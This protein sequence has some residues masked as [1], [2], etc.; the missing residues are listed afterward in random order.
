MKTILSQYLLKIVYKELNSKNINTPEYK[1]HLEK[2][3][4]ILNTNM[5]G[6]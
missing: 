2:T 3:F 5:A 1:C 6:V 4:K